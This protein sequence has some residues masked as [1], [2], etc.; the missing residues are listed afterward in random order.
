MGHKSLINQIGYV[1]PK[2]QLL[3]DY[4]WFGW[5]YYINPVAYSFEAVVTNEFAG[6]TMQCSP[7]QLVPQGPGVQERYQGCS[8]A[9]AAV[10]AHSVEGSA[11]L[12]ASY[13]EWKPNPTTK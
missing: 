7:S 6:R 10:G 2:T 12:E 4:I 5:I 13:S 8:V 3:G 11:Y 9:G 1:I